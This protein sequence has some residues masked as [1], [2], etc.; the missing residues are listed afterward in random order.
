[1]KQLREANNMK[2]LWKVKGFEKQTSWKVSVPD[3]F[4]FFEKPS[5]K[6][7]A[8]MYIDMFL[9]TVI[10]RVC[11][12]HTTTTH[13]TTHNDTHHTTKHTNKTPITHQH[14]THPHTAHTHTT[15]TH[16]ARRVRANM[17]G[18]E[19]WW[20][21]LFKDT[22]SWSLGTILTCESFVTFHSACFPQDRWSWTIFYQVKRMIGGMGK[23]LF[24]TS[25]KLQYGQDPA[26]TLVNPWCTWQFSA[27]L[28]IFQKQLMKATISA[29]TVG[30]TM[31]TMPK[32][33]T[34]GALQKG[35][36]DFV[37]IRDRWEND[38]Q[39][40]ETQMTHGWTYAWV[41]FLDHIAKLDISHAATAEQRGR[42]QNL[43]YLRA[44]GKDLNGPLFASRPRYQEAENVFK[45]YAGAVAKKCGNRI[46]PT[47][48][49][50]AIEWS[51][52][53]WYKRVPS[54]ASV[55]IG[56]NISQTK[57]KP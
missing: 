51:T 44:F 19:R 20:I 52:S 22:F 14:T 30:Y 6:S 45:R 25:L 55:R 10:L 35:K 42:Y 9:C 13:T 46:H 12:G 50:E 34:H 11:V 2:P 7:D 31:Y 36:R 57:S 49:Q 18:P 54:V 23:M 33:K 29:Y 48:C 40:K 37:S 17:S 5:K 43:L 41:R 27:L 24:S 28:V 16:T 32:Q 26:L 4:F 39:N 8:D 56:L 21:V 38:S 47:K 3:R 53:S 1:M 15:H